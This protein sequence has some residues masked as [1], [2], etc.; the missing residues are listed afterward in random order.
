MYLTVLDIFLG[1][2][3]MLP[4][5]PVSLLGPQTPT[6]PSSTSPKRDSEDGDR[7]YL[8]MTGIRI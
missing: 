1:K 7:E 6:G 8:S 2:I 3:G 5:R 4:K